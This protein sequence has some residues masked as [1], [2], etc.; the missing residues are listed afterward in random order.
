MRTR[1][2]TFVIAAA[3][4]MGCLDLTPRVVPTDAAVDPIDSGHADPD[5]GPTACWICINTPSTP[6]PG[7][8]S[9]WAGCSVD[10]RCRIL[11]ECM[12]EIGCFKLADRGQLIECIAV[13]GP[14]INLTGGTDHAITLMTPV[15]MCTRLGPCSPTCVGSEPSQ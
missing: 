9:E 7:C 3:C 13:C 11:V 2:V 14:R 6:G 1:L 10:S 8:A 5:A 12:E 15:T 4:A